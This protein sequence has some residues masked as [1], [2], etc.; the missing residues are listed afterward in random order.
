MNPL[1]YAKM[2]RMPGSPAGT[3]HPAARQRIFSPIS[4]PALATGTVSGTLGDIPMTGLTAHSVHRCEIGR[5]A[6][7][8]Y[9]FQLGRKSHPG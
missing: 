5:L 4:P 7:G 3:R 1:Q 9:G 6:P 2:G 8:S